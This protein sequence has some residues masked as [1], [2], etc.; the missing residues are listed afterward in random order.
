MVLRR[1]LIFV[2]L[3]GLRFNVTIVEERKKE[4]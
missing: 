4:S 2:G 1:L 3:V